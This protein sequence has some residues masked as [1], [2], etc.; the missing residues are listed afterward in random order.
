MMKKKNRDI[1]G[2]EAIIKVCG[3]EVYENT[4][5][6][7][8]KYTIVWCPSINLHA[9]GCKPHLN[10]SEILSA[11]MD[12]RKRHEVG[13]TMTERMI[14]VYWQNIIFRELYNSSIDFERVSQKILES[15]CEKIYNHL[16]Q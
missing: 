4:T 10:K 14:C 15:L 1:K 13:F 5:W 3:G 9:L 7:G 6:R 16:Q 12:L 2:I 8:E 11:L